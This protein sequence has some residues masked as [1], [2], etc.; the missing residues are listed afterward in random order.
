M[1]IS[2]P[3]HETAFIVGT[4][5]HKPPP[6]RSGPSR[7]DPGR[8]DGAAREDDMVSKVAVWIQY[9]RYNVSVENE[10]GNEIRC[11]GAYDDLAEAR[12]MA[13]R[14]AE[15]LGGLE[16]TVSTTYDGSVQS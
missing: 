11:V 12:A 8:G 1:G 3:V 14:T 2:S 16:V 7:G 6:S 10:E 5:H 13:V 15:R 9:G 4:T